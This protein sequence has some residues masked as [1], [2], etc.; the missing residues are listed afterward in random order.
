MREVVSDHLTVA[1][2]GRG[3]V[4]LQDREEETA[5]QAHEQHARGGRRGAA[6]I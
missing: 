4:S 6:I 2:I 1:L 3:V 5:E